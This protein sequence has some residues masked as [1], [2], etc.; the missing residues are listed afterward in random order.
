MQCSDA[1]A[2][3][4]SVT[5]SKGIFLGELV[6]IKSVVYKPTLL[7][8][9]A[10]HFEGRFKVLS[11]WKLIDKK[12]VWLALPGKTTPCTQFEEGKIY[13]VYAN[14]TGTDL[15]IAEDSRSTNATAELARSDLQKLGESQVVVR[16]GEFSLRPSPIYDLSIAALIIAVCIFL[17][18]MVVKPI[19]KENF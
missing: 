13:L 6:E 2:F 12:Y 7:H 3:E 4:T 5:A 8:D 16:D 1:N 14:Q 18:S 19:I 10:V 9:G 17:G 11:S 15:F